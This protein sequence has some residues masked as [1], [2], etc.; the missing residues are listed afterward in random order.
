MHLTMHLVV[1]CRLLS[2]AAKLLTMFY[3]MPA[4][5]RVDIGFS[6]MLKGSN[7]PVSEEEYLALLQ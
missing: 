6:K 2:P 1:V 7:K 3:R 4:Y 5:R